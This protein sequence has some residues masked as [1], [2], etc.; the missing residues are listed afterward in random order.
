[1]IIT[2]P[3]TA[4]LLGCL[5]AAILLVGLAPAADA[6]SKRVGCFKQ[7]FPAPGEK[8]K[9]RKKPSK[10][11]FIDKDGLNSP[12]PPSRSVQVTENVRWS[13]WGGRRAKGRGQGYVGS[14]QFPV[15]IRI[16]LSK[17]KKRCG[18]KVYSKAEFRFPQSGAET[19]PFNLRTC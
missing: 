5:L 15:Q 1:M 18:R 10:C 9:F 17:P 19:G 14:N 16:T 4:G 6:R 13:N 12:V 3:I 8:P 2:K 7:T 11:I